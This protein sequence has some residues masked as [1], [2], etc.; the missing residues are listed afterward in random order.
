MTRIAVLLVS[1]AAAAWLASAYPG[2][3]AEEQ[4]REIRPAPGRP[5]TTG[6]VARSIELLEDARRA[7]PDGDILPRL[8]GLELTAGRPDEAAALVR[9][10]VRREPENLPAWTILA[11]ALERS[12]PAGARE[13]QRRR[14]ELAPPVR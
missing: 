5:L 2:T 14:R 3:R 10:L 7:R 4:A 9:P 11:F 8:A 13:A 1:L 12:D 6:Q